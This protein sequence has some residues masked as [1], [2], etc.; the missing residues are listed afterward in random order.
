[1]LPQEIK[2]LKRNISRRLKPHFQ[3]LMANY[4]FSFEEGMEMFFFFIQHPI[5]EQELAGLDLTIVPDFYKYYVDATTYH[6]QFSLIKTISTCLEAMLKKILYYVDNAKYLSL[7]TKKKG[8][9]DIILALP[10]LIKDYRTKPEEIL[11]NSSNIMPTDRGIPYDMQR[12]YE[13]RN[14][15]HGALELEDIVLLQMFKS[16]TMVYL[17]SFFEYWEILKL[18]P[19]IKDQH[20]EKDFSQGEENE[21]REKIKEIISVCYTRAVFTKIHGQLS[22]IAMLESLSDS[23]VALQ[24]RAINIEPESARALVIQMI[25]EMDGIERLVCDSE[26]FNSKKHLQL[27]PKSLK[28]LAAYENREQIDCAKLRIIASLI[29]LSQFIEYEFDIP[30]SLTQRNSFFTKAEASLKP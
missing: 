20:L 10:N 22:I 6:E 26:Y 5:P 27:D 24:K 7:K 21:A 15:V 23:R 25:S 2:A 19:S 8:L 11:Y 13:T 18:H 28:E 14:T 16:C 12:A 30:K 17:Y 4:S 9:K 3:N 1:M 29:S